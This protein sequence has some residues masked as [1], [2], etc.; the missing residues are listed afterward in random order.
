MLKWKIKILA[1][2]LG[3]LREKLAD[4]EGLLEQAAHEVPHDGNAEQLIQR[5]AKVGGELDA[6]M[7]IVT[8]IRED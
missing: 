6:L 2:E 5:L 8:S 1:A 7:P 4:L 3:E